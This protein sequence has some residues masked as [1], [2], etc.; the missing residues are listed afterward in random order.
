MIK[1][2]FTSNKAALSKVIVPL[3]SNVDGDEDQDVLITGSASSGG[4]QTLYQ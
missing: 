1:G 4:S 2:N 3:L